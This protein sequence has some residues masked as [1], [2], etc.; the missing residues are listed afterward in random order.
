MAR[1]S[2]D[3][4]PSTNASMP[5]GAAWGFSSSPSAAR[6]RP[7]RSCFGLPWPTA[8]KLRLA[9]DR[10]GLGITP[11]ISSCDRNQQACCGGL[12]ILDPFKPDRLPSGSSET[13]SDDTFSSSQDEGRACSGLSGLLLCTGTSVRT[14]MTSL[15]FII[16][17]SSPSSTT[18]VPD[19]LPN[20]TR[21]PTLRSIGIS[22]PDSSRPPGPTAVISPCEGFSLA[23]S[24]L[25]SDMM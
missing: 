20:S 8:A 2:I 17:R 25:K 4:E 24:N 23:L 9:S 1:T 22:L 3:R 10:E 13:F 11:R 7:A 15:S 12:S 18:S 5:E 6:K 14:P 21:S 16:R 19:H